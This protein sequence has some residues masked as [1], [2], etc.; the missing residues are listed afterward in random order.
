MWKKEEKTEGEGLSLNENG[1]LFHPISFLPLSA[2]KSLSITTG[3][4][5]SKNITSEGEETPN[6]ERTLYIC[7]L[8]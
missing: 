3:C 1:V 7:V 2:W 6:V 4:H 5:I 8:I